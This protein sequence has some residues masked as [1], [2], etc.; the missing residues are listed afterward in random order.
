MERR[1]GLTKILV[2]A[3]VETLEAGLAAEEA[4]ADRVELCAHLDQEG[5]TPDPAVVGALVGRLHIPVF[6]IVRPRAGGFVYDGNELEAM[7]RDAGLAGAAGV[8]GIATGALRPDGRIDATATRAMVAAAD[9]IPVTFHRAFD[10]VAD[11]TAALETLIDAGVARALTSGGAP[12]AREG[13][14]TIGALVRQA[15]GRIEIVAGGGVRAHNVRETIARTGVREVHSR[16]I[17]R[18]GLRQLI[19]AA[20]RDRSPAV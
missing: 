20:Q 19:A 3:A 5:L 15:R 14:A 1:S 2:E 6:I 10:L 11:K 12:T 4:G 13:A 9:G 16:F 7:L 8:A 18:D 17:D